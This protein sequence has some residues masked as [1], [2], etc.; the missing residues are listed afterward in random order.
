ML[1]KY[2]C[3]FF[4]YAFLGWCMETIGEFLKSG[5]T[6]NRG[7][8]IGPY[9]PVYGIGVVLIT[10]FLS[11]YV[12]DFLVMFIMSIVICGTLEYFTSYIM[13]K[14]FNAR[15]WDYHNRKFNINGRICLETL[16]PFGLVGTILVKFVTPF[17]LGIIFKVPIGILDFI[18]IILCT[19]ILIDIIVSFNV[20]LGFRKTT[21]QV[22]KEVKDN[23][24]EVSKKVKEITT[25]KIR[26]I[27]EFATKEIRYAKLSLENKNRILILNMKISQNK[28][29]R[30]IKYTHKKI[31]ENITEGVKIKFTENSWFSQRLAKAFPNLEVKLKNKT[32]NRNK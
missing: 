16:I 24:E 27:K 13:E 23:T 8:L 21:K 28:F 10:I 19:I 26:E 9:C 1:E 15:W 5:K 6:V 29:K 31:W 32:K 3:I 17:F 2:I 25:E 20:I 4:I 14:L 7:F 30:R 11:K 22:E 12:N 18:L